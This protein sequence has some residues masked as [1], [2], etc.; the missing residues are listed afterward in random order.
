MLDELQHLNKRPIRLKLIGWVDD[1]GHQV[2][3]MSVVYRAK[4][5]AVAHTLPDARYAQAY[6]GFE[7]MAQAG[8]RRSWRALREG[9]RKQMHGENFRE[10]QAI[11]RM[12]RAQ[13]RDWDQFMA[14]TLMPWNVPHEREAFRV[15][16]E[17]RFGATPPYTGHDYSRRVNDEHRFKV[18]TTGTY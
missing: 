18:Q 12:K 4:R 7:P 2:V 14:P 13:L 8:L 11:E 17:S 6:Q 5:Y 16:I 9:L 1:M 10:R 15:E 3:E